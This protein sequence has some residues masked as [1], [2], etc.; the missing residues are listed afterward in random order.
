MQ[1]PAHAQAQAH[2]KLHCHV[3]QYA[4]G[5]GVPCAWLNGLWLRPCPGMGPTN[6]GA[7]G[8]G[9]PRRRR[10]ARNPPSLLPSGKA[11]W[12]PPVRMTSSVPSEASGAAR[13]AAGAGAWAG[14][15]AACLST[16]TEKPAGP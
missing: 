7:G 13:G 15:G 10:P 2:C 12:L 4:P 11:G 14:A 6:A 5:S 9:A 8:A 1:H 3:R 16:F